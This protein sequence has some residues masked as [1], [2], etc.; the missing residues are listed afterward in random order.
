MIIV[1]QNRPAY[2]GGCM[3]VCP[4]KALRLAGNG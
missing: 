3:S 4:V 1:D 2:I